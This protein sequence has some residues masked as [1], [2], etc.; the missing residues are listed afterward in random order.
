MYSTLVLQSMLFWHLKQQAIEA[1]HALQ[2]L[3]DGAQE[4]VRR[5]DLRATFCEQTDRE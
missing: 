5:G 4:L 1:A 2:Q 3:A